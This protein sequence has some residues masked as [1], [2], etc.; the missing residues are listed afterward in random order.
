MQASGRADTQAAR[1]STCQSGWAT[2]CRITRWASCGSRPSRARSRTP[3]P[4]RTYA[5]WTRRKD[6]WPARAAGPPPRGFAGVSLA[7]SSPPSPV[8]GCGRPVLLGCLVGLG[9]GQKL[10]GGLMPTRVISRGR[11]CAVY[12]GSRRARL[13]I[14]P[15]F[16]AMASTHPLNCP[17]MLP[18]TPARAAAMHSGSVF[19]SRAAA[20]S[21][22]RMQFS[23]AA[24]LITILA[25]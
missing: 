23:L 4:S 21:S 7:G 16:C 12:V 2:G 20:G 8:A 9:Y 18:A 3:R 17:P 22:L 1:P 5:G 19:L 6:A 11:V 13:E 25:F 14:S 10:A 15:P 24:A